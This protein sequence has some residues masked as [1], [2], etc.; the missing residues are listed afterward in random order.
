M[1]YHE[2]GGRRVLT[3]TVVAHQAFGDQLRFDAHVRASVL[4]GGFDEEGTFFYIPGSG[5]QSTV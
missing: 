3:G 1:F 2:V 5:L 4:D